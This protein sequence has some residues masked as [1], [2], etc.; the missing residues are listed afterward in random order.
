M[1][2]FVNTMFGS[3]VSPKNH[4]WDETVY[5]PTFTI[6]NQL[7]VGK[8]ISP[9]DAFRSDFTLSNPQHLISPN[10]PGLKWGGELTEAGINDAE[11]GRL[12][13]RRLEGHMWPSLGGFNPG[14]IA[15]KKCFKKKLM[16]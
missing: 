7:N 10:P 4:P 16:F 9:M 12:D 15:K 3:K 2:F 14:W 13:K 1:F 8:C 5:L 6:K 11:A